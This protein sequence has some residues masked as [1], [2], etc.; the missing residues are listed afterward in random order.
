MMT[1]SGQPHSALS[2][3]QIRK[4][5]HSGTPPELYQGKR[6]LVLTPDTTRTCPLPLMVSILQEVVGSTADKLDFIVA[7]GTH[8]PLSEE[9][10][11]EL[12]GISTE[13]RET[14]FAGTKFYNHR[15]DRPETFRRIG[16]LSEEE[17]DELSAGRLR[18]KVPVDINKII[19]EYDQILILG[20]VF[21]HEVAGYSGGAK[22]F[23]P[24]ISGGEFLHFFHWSLSWISQ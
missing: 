13:A 4:I 23:F 17:T 24:G 5:I 8:Q 16:Y 9:R 12:Y 7:L 22:Y 11:L 20:P 6:V 1:G 19:F 18:E 14:T 3:A 10:I 21:P 2:E 15:W